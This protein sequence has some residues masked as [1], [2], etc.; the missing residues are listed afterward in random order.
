MNH[1]ISYGPYNIYLV[2]FH[3]F[4]GELV[5]LSPKCYYAY[6]EENGKVKKGTKGVPSQCKMKLQEFKEK[7]YENKT[8]HVTVRSLRSV[9]NHMS[10][11]TQIKKGLS[12]L[13][14]KFYVED[15]GI[16]CTPLKYTGEYL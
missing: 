2:E 6:D 10:R 1:A 7:L 3:F 15:D 16:T 12:S 13:F 4:K 5:A 8:P 9:Q 14:C 11:T